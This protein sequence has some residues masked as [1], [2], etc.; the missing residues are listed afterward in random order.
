MITFNRNKT[1]HCGF[2]LA[3][4]MVS[5][6]IFSF[7]LVGL[8]SATLSGARLGQR[9]DRAY[10]AYNLAASHIELL[11]HVSF[12]ELEDAAEVD[13]IINAY[14]NPDLDGEYLRT[15]QISTDYAGHASLTSAMV[16]VSCLTQD[17]KTDQPVELTGLIYN[18]T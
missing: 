5:I 17:G 10:A 7:G 11:R 1:N 9:A 2:S 16:R 18:G 14:G 4:V 12:E 3:E 6:M 13:T 8:V 15:T